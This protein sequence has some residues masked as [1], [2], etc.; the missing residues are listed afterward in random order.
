MLQKIRKIA[1]NFIVRCLLALMAFAFI[2]WGAK[3]VLQDQ[4]NYEL[5]KFKHTSS[6]TGRD[7]LKAK[8]EMISYLQKHDQSLNEEQIKNLGLN[9]EVLQR[10]INEKM[11]HYLSDYYELIPSENMVIKYLT[12]LPEF[13]DDNGNFDVNK[14]KYGI[15]HSGLK[16]TDFINN[17]SKEMTKNNIIQ[18]FANG[19]KIADKAT[20]NMINYLAETY[21]VNLVKINLSN[22]KKIEKIIAPTPEELQKFYQTKIELF[23]IPE[24]RELEYLKI[25]NKFLEDKITVSEEEVTEFYN[26]NKEELKD[27]TLAKSKP[28]IIEKIKK[29]KYEQNL[30][31]TMKDVEDSVA[32]GS[33]LNEI[34]KR[35]NLKTLI[36]GGVSQKNINEI[37]IKIDELTDNIF[38]MRSGEVSYPV[39][40][41]DKSGIFLVEIKKI[42][43]SFVQ[44]Y[45]IVREKVLSLWEADKF[46]EINY[47]ALVTLAKNYIATEVNTKNL[48]SYGIE[49]DQKF[50]INRNDLSSIKDIPTNLLASIFQTQVSNNT[51]VFIQD[52]YAYFA[53]LK[54]KAID[55]SK[56]KEIEK[57]SKNKIESWMRNGVFEELLIY[58]REQN[59]IKI[60][61]D[62]SL[63][64]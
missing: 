35:L 7:F 33:S 44:N 12:N 17:F 27:Q 56:A 41:K 45:D 51:A 15:S 54:S 47:Q 11:L 38:E 19:F 31:E 48:A 3:D 61:F 6:I 36:A 59:D 9:Q 24:M 28:Q 50:S 63:N 8:A 5:V 10:L 64:R 52:N 32:S 2:G 60:N 49:V 4:N 25:S 62:E 57:S 22:Q 58:L 43:P 20:S 42:S 39:E 55:V 1:N 16:E 21:K 40:F 23:T 37:K 26:E 14:F 53:H 30:I 13:K 29:Q 18:T 34:A 46:K